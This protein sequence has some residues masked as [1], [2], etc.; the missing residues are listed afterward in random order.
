[1]SVQLLKLLQFKNIRYHIFLSRYPQRLFELV[2][3]AYSWSARKANKAS[4][5]MIFLRQFNTES[6][7]VTT[8]DFAE[9]EFQSL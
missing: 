8:P 6:Q 1:M 2:H 3:C 9:N 5:Q 7:S 4:W